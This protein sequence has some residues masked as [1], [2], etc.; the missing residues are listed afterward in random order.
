M[1]VTVIPATPD[2]TELLLDL[3]QVYMKDL[4]DF[5]GT[6]VQADG[7][8]RDDR[9]RTYLAYEEHWAL[10]IRSK[11]KVAGFA[12][13]RK[14]KSDT[15]LM[16]EF[17]IKPE[18]RRKGIGAASV[19]QILLMFKGKWEIPFQNEN[20]KAAIFWREVIKELGF[21]SAESLIPVAGKPHLPHDVWMSFTS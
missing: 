1:S 13:V 11:E 2:E 4:A 19:A 7:R 15:H 6:L 10:I 9:L 20:D 18:F 12:L 16:G 3:W 14:P 21:V 5:R 17:F 8:Y